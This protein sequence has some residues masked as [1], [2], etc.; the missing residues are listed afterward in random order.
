MGG[1]HRQP[2]PSELGQ[3]RARRWWM[4]LAFVVLAGGCAMSGA[5]VSQW[6]GLVAGLP[7]GVVINLAEMR[8]KVAPEEFKLFVKE[9]PGSRIAEF[10]VWL[11]VAG[12]G[13]FVQPRVLAWM[14]AGAWL[15]DFITYYRHRP[16]RLRHLYA[17]TMAIDGFRGF[18][19]PWAYPLPL[20]AWAL[21][22]P[23]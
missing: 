5:G 20:L 17:V 11:G 15:Y 6:L 3:D 12:A 4:N 7:L 2:D 8:A 10:V 9:L 14:L 16:E 21:F 13:I 23:R 19:V 1:S 18:H 22:G